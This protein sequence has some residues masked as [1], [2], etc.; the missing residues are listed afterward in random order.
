MLKRLPIAIVVAALLLNDIV[1]WFELRTGMSWFLGELGTLAAASVLLLANAV[2]ASLFFR[3]LGHRYIRRLHL[4]AALLYST[5]MVA[6]YAVAVMHGTIH[7]PAELATDAFF[8]IDRRT[9]TVAGAFIVG[10][11]L[12]ATTFVFW[13]VLGAAIRAHVEQQD[14]VAWQSKA[15]AAGLPTDNILAMRKNA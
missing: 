8:G 12:A 7:L 10:T 15:E 13:S 14:L 1:T 4:V 9:V 6:V 3:G 5:I 2:T 11:A